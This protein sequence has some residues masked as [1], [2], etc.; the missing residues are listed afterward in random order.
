MPARL[1]DVYQRTVDIEWVTQQLY[2]PTGDPVPGRLAFQTIHHGFAQ[3]EGRHVLGEHP[4]LSIT[5][6][7]NNFSDGMF[8]VL[9]WALPE[10]GAR[11]RS[12]AL[13]YAPKPR[14]VPGPDWG[15]SLLAEFPEMQRWS[16]FELTMEGCVT[17]NGRLDPGE[18]QFF[19]DLAEIE[20]HLTVTFPHRGCRRNLSVIDGSGT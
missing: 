3:F 5:S 2:S 8:R 7:N 4:L 20:Q 12:D 17:D 10:P 6:E 18:A 15:P 14:F 19:A 9:G 16:L 1:L 11:V 13:L